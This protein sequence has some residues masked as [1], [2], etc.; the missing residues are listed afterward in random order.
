MLCSATYRYNNHHFL[1]AVPKIS[2]KFSDGY[3]S[4]TL[5]A[6]AR[7]PEALFRL[8]RLRAD[9]APL[10]GPKNIR[11]GRRVNCGKLID[12]QQRRQGLSRFSQCYPRIE[13]M[14]E[15]RTLESDEQKSYLIIGSRR[16]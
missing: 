12:P 7:T 10:P 2:V 1:D 8:D 9:D 11:N 4:D 16:I 6:A 15:R 14:L 13:Q 3:F 5:L